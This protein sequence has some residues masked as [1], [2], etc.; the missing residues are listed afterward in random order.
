MTADYLGAV[1]RNCSPG[2]ATTFNFYWPWMGNHGVFKTFSGD[3]VAPDTMVNVWYDKARD[4]R[5]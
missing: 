5:S 4:T 2:L 1:A 3:G